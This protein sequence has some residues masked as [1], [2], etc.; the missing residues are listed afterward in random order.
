MSADTVHVW[1]VDA[2]LPEPVLAAL[3]DLLDDDE[4]A[5]AGGLG[6][7]QSRRR[8][9][10]AHAAARLI[11]ARRLGAPP[12][13]LRWRRGRHGKPE[14]AGR[15]T[16]PRISL[17]HSGPLV[18]VAVTDRRPVGVDIQELSGRLAA[19]RLAARYFPA[20]EARLVAGAGTPAGQVDR[21][22]RLWARKEACVKAAGGRLVQGLRLP[23]T[24]TGGLRADPAGRLVSDPAGPLP[25]PFRVMDVPAPSGFRAAV[26]LI[27][28]GGFRVARHRW[29]PPAGDEPA[30]AWLSERP[31]L[32]RN[33]SSRLGR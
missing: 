23:V 12:E 17:S 30:H 27:G 25:G 18:L 14:L 21:L 13:Q 22:A 1:L 3:A 29:Q 15:W 19:P 4:R 7:E 33:T 2:D 20:P 28:A 32:A 16:G 8:F 11:V 10:A 31:V 5:R 6:N 9:V 24:G 26:A